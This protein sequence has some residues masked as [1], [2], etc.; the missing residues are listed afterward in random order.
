[1]NDIVNTPVITGIYSA[2]FAAIVA[3]T[4][5]VWFLNWRNK[6]VQHCLPANVTNVMV[7]LE[8]LGTQPGCKILS[9]GAATFDAHG[10]GRAFYIEVARNRGQDMLVEDPDT[11]EW[12]AK[13]T[14][15][16]KTLLATPDDEKVTLTAALISFNQWLREVAE[17]DARNNLRVALWGN[18]SD[19]DNAILAH[20]CK[21][22]NVRPGW[23]FWG[24]R[25]YRTL[26]NLAPDIAVER[27]GIHHNALDDALTQADHA[28]QILL[29]LDLWA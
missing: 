25:C 15:E 18:G 6:R 17:T 10:A 26:K 8:T 2:A 22:V 29:E 24:N 28:A 1:M 27:I 14:P 9:I 11:L 21:A 4:A 7:D 5:T 3:V 13:Q 23:P 19:F 20:A 12:W 16:A